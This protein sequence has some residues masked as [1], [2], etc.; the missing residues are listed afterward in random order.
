MKILLCTAT[1]S[2]VKS[3]RKQIKNLD[4]KTKLPIEYLCTGIGNYETIKTLTKYLTQ[5]EEQY[6]ILNIGVCGYLDRKEES[7]QIASI[8]NLHTKKESIVPIFLEFGKLRNIVSSEH[9]VDDSK[10]LEGFEGREIYVDMESRGIE[11]VA[12]HFQL[13]RLLLKVPVD[14][15]GEETK[16]FN[17]QLS[18]KLL[19]EHINYEKLMTNILHYIKQLET[20]EDS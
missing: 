17:Y 18:L 8:T 19:E 12:Q 13:P 20:K 9:I 4:L 16:D 15:V 11:I 5:K 2:E 7:I 3:I 6:F 10:Y 1:P 14:K